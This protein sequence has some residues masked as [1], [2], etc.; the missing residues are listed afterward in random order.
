MDSAQQTGHKILQKMTNPQVS[1]VSF[2]RKKEAVTMSTKPAVKIGSER[3]SVDPQLL[4]Q[5]FLHVSGGDMSKLKEI[6]KY[7][8]TAMPLISLFDDSRFMR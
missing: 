6:F 1:A 7:E 8:L 4:F 3:V 5:R 2:K